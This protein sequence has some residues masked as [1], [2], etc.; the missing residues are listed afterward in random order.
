MFPLWRPVVLV[1]S[2]VGKRSFAVSGTLDAYV[3]SA[4]VC[5][6]FW[7]DSPVWLAVVVGLGKRF[8]RP[9]ELQ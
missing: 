7:S 9:N 1:A 6:S 4:I 8:A 5:V 3:S 2:V